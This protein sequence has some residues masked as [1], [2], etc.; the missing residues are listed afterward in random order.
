MQRGTNQISKTIW[1]LLLIEI[2]AVNCD[3]FVISNK[4]LNEKTIEKKE[5]KCYSIATLHLTEIK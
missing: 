4:N 5:Q 2:F 1:F 3:V